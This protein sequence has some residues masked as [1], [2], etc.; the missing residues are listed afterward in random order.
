MDDRQAGD[1]AA[2][3]RAFLD[4]LTAVL[5]A[6]E[7]IRAA[8]VTGSLARGLADAYSDVDVLIAVRDAD[9]RDFVERWRDLLDRVSPTVLARR[10]GPDDAPILNAITPDWVR[11]DIVIHPAANPRPRAG[12]AELL[13][14]RDGIDERVRAVPAPQRDPLARLPF[15]VEEFIRGL[16]LLPIVIGRD[17]LLVAMFGVAILRNHLIDLLLLENGVERGGAKRVNPLLT[18]E[19]RRALANLPPE[20]PTHESLIEVHLAYARLFLPRA[21]RLLAEHGL[22]YPE[23]FERATFA[24][25]RRTLGATP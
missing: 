5:R 9:F 4:R 1:G 20:S 17:E 13:F 6:D 2:E 11:F 10:I 3:Q 7:R 19:Q 14:D 15:L 18:E 12:A 8:W 21:R 25:L 23:A 24:Y 22:P 16:G